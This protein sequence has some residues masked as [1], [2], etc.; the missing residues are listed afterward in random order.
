[1]AQKTDTT[2][3]N[4]IEDQQFLITCNGHSKVYWGATS[5]EALSKYLRLH[6]FMHKNSKTLNI[7][8]KPAPK[9][10]EDDGC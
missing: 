3:Q 2:E 7:E 10:P 6:T 5:I 8:C 9:F 1:M 4:K